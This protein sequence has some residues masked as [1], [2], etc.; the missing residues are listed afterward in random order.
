M[1]W[2][3]PETPDTGHFSVTEFSK[4]YLGGFHKRINFEAAILVNKSLSHVE[5]C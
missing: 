3:S 1:L 2:I 5:Y 4:Y